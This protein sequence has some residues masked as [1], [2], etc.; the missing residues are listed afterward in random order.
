PDI[1]IAWS[2]KTPSPMVYLSVLAVL[3]YFGGIIAY[4]IGKAITRIPSVN[5][6]L[7]VKIAKH[8]R[9]TRRWGGFLIIVGALL[10]IP[11]S[12]TTLAA[13]IINYSEKGVWLFGL[14]RFLRFYLYAI[15]IFS[16]IS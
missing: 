10:P 14:F 8:I 6:Y 5:N 7:N 9:N 2:G 16:V 12:M 15:A 13:G 11:F 3:S 4:Y 1:F